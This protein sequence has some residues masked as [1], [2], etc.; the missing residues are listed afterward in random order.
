MHLHWNLFRTL[1]VGRADFAPKTADGLAGCDSIPTIVIQL[2]A[3]LGQTRV[4]MTKK[5]AV[6][7]RPSSVQRPSVLPRIER[8]FLL[9]LKRQSN[10]RT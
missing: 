1:I 3:P 7:A 5:R 9:P 4:K 10:S 8:L 6:Y 2:S